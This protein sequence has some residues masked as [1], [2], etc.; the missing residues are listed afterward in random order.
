MVSPDMATGRSRRRGKRQDR[1]RNGECRTVDG[2]VENQGNTKA[3][4]ASAEMAT[5]EFRKGV[6]RQFRS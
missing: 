4:M 2:R 5:G 1:G 3:E 6:S